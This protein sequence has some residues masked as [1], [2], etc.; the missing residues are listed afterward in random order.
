MKENYLQNFHKNPQF[1]KKL[2]EFSQYFVVK[3]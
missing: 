1:N 2:R 3:I